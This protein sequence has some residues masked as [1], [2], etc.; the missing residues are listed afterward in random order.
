MTDNDYG[1][2]YFI[3]LFAANDVSSKAL[4]FAIL[5][6]TGIDAMSFQPARHLVHSNGEHVIIPSDHIDLFGNN[7]CCGK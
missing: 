2:R 1:M 4:P 5:V 3:P 7:G 6:D